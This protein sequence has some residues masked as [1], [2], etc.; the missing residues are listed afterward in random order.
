MNVSSESFL[1]FLS[2]Q[3]ELSVLTSH[4]ILVE[5]V[6]RVSS[7][8]ARMCEDVSEIQMESSL[9]RSVNSLDIN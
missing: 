3:T 4:P 6:L 9:E 1:S 8:K 7:L 2:V 5:G